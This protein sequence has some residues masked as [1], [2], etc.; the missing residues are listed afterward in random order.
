MASSS[1]SQSRSHNAQQPPSLRLEDY[2]LT[3]KGVDDLTSL[4]R[5]MPLLQNI[6]MP[7][8]R[9]AAIAL[10]AS[11]GSSD[12]KHALHPGTLHSAHFAAHSLTEPNNW[13]NSLR[14]DYLR[15][16]MDMVRAP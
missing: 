13:R 7:Q 2:Q 9:A 5:M 1:S 4:L 10:L 6:S 12:G 16:V 14:D 3:A 8:L 11:G 15:L